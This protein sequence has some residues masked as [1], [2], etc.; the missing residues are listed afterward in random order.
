MWET[1]LLLQI[2]IQLR[3]DGD[4]N[5]V[6]GAEVKWTEDESDQVSAVHCLEQESSLGM[7]G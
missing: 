6:V 1:D 4:L 7:I 5:E 3:E 2:S